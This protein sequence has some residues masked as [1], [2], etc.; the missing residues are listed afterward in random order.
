VNVRTNP[1]VATWGE[2]EG[3]MGGGGVGER[4]VG[5]GVS[6]L[7]SLSPP[8]P[9]HVKYTTPPLLIPALILLF[10]KAFKII[11]NGMIPPY[12]HVGEPPKKHF[13]PPPSPGGLIF[14]VYILSIISLVG[15]GE[16]GLAGFKPHHT[17][18]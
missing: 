4:D 12:P 18:P 14:F 1:W 6:Y 7:S 11:S 2:R 16:W 3:G 10:H 9:P 5:E 15:G 13:P 8:S 17:H